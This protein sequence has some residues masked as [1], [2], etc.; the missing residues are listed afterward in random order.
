MSKSIFLF[1]NQLEKGTVQADSSVLPS[2]NLVNR[3][4]TKVWRSATN[5]AW[6]TVS[7]NEANGADY[8]ALV[9]LNMTTAGMIR[10][11]AWTDAVNGTQLEFD[12][13]YDP[14]VFSANTSVDVDY[15]LG[16]YGLGAYGTNTPLTSSSRKNVQLLPFGQTLLSPFYR[17]DFMDDNLQYIQ[18]G[19]MFLSQSRSFD[20]NLAYD[21]NIRQ[22]DRSVSKESIAGQRYIQPRDTR[23]EIQGRFPALNESER[24]DMIVAITEVGNTKPFIYSVFP[25]NNNVGLTTSLY[26]AF[27]DSN[28]VN[29]FENR[30][31][32]NFTVTEE[33]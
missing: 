31:D 20:V 19:V 10:V 14:V 28:I 3:Q 26:G 25:E 2:S 33:L 1:S 18:L 7:L 22:I 17:I 23:L 29:K 30:N 9:D 15:G 12:Q 24:T 6:V 4:R 5:N 11:R 13:Y 32:F 8:L 27:S 21:W 16:D